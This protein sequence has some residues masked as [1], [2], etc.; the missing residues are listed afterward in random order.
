ML[1]I[2]VV[3][4][5]MNLNHSI[6]SYL[7]RKD[8]KVLGALNAEEGYD[9]LFSNHVDLIISDIMMPGIN[10]FEFVKTIRRLNDSIPMI[11][12]TARDD[13]EAKQ[14][15]FKVGIDDYMTKP[16]NMEEMVLRINALFRRSRIE[17]NK[18]LVMGNFK[19]NLDEHMAYYK[20]QPIKLTA[21][22][23]DLVFKFLSYP[24]KTFTRGQ[25]MDGF[26]DSETKTSTRTVDVYMTKIREKLSDVD[27]FEIVT[28]HGLGYKVIP[29]E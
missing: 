6:C 4:D 14:K 5:D 19:M 27:D 26:W 21:R 12:M 23:F 29:N 17:M 7:I 8:F 28:V 18:Q 13:F 1:T 15:G 3:E 16:I 20:N 25:L 24:K 10:G 11:F 22:E 9:F 2:L